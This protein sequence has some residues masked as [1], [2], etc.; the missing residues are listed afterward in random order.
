MSVLANKQH[1]FNFV[2]CCLFG[3]TAAFVNT[4]P[5]LFIDSSEFLLGQ[6]FVLLSLLLF[7]WRYAILVFCFSTLGIFYRWGH[8]W[9]SI[10]FGLEVIWVYFLCLRFARPLFFRT[11]LFWLLIGMPLLWLLGH[12]QLQLPF[13]TL[14]TALSKYGINAAIYLCVIDLFSFFF[15]RHSWYRHYGSLYKILNYIVTLLVILIVVLTSVVLINNHYSRIEY[16]VNAQLNEKSQQIATNLD[17]YLENHRKAILLT[18]NTI[19][20]GQAPQEALNLLAQLYPGIITAIITD[21]LANVTHYHPQSF[22]TQLLKGQSIPNVADRA[23][24]SSGKTAQ[25]G[26]ISDIFQGRGFGQQSIVAISAP[27]HINQQ[28]SGIVEGS[29]LFESFSELRPTLFKRQADL[30]LLD[31]SNQVV[32]STLDEFKLM[33]TLTNE[34]IITL[35]NESNEQNNTF[36]AASGQQYYSKEAKSVIN[37]WR[38]FTLMNKSYVNNVAAQAWG[39][40]LALIIF[41]ILLTSVFITQLSKWLVTPILK[42][43]AQINSFAADKH[44]SGVIAQ[45][46]T[47]HEVERLQQQFAQLALNLST[48]FNELR[49]ANSKNSALNKQLKNFNEGLEQQVKDKTAELCNAVAAANKANQTKSLFLAN[50][51]HEIRTPL[52][53]ILGMTQLLIKNPNIADSEREEL[54]MIQQS[55]HNLL[56]ILNEILDFSKIEANALKLDLQAVEIKALIRQLA[57]VFE[58]SGLNPNV[59]FKLFIAP[60]LPPYIALDALRFSQVI[61]NILSNAGKFTETG[62]ITMDCSYDDGCLVIKITDTGIGISKRQRQTLFT[63][64][65]QAD[66]STTRKYGGT[67]LGLTIS[68]RLIELMQGTLSLDSEQGV[69]SRF[70][71]TLP[72]VVKDAP[73]GEITDSTVPNLTKKR[74]LIVEDNQINQI[75]LSKMMAETGCEIKTAADGYEA[76]ECLVSYPADLILMDCQMPNMDGYQCTQKIRQMQ[77]ESKQVLIIAITAN[78][79]AEDKEKCLS[80]GMNDFIAKPINKIELYQCINNI[81][82]SNRETV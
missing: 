48:S 61:N 12:Y 60:E 37:D 15:N 14:I 57:T 78:A 64:F 27:I 41:I 28:F 5:I 46:E 32:F 13:L 39:Q 54:Q 34:N 24:F 36:T 77:S 62:T 22:K 67:G 42:L 18:A 8:A 51:S 56:L 75:V 35:Q 6:F 82:N 53:G 29:L 9:P 72:I 17:S 73:A 74:V 25:R 50:M 26:F 2:V 47:W 19:A 40:S 20:S 23:Y 69:G 4:L 65:T 68:K 55:A 44:H 71:I 7:G 38:V 76:L 59:S 66:I 30:I 3:I 10:V 43:T 21:E 52:N 11:L 45:S 81:L 16:E 63:E 70:K 31:K 58:N 33:Q 49:T 1:V 80:A 79:F